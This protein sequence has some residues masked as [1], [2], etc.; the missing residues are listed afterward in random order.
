MNSIK[1][2]FREN[3]YL[4]FLILFVGLF[5][6]NLFFGIRVDND[7]KWFKRI[8]TVYQD[9]FKYLKYRYDSY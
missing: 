7:E 4:G 1:K 9:D 8:Q 3:T 5:I 2:N 6:V